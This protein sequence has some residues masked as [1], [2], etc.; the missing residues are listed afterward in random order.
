[1]EPG[2]LESQMSPGFATSMGP[3]G[4]KNYWRVVVGEC[5]QDLPA[6]RIRWKSSM[7]LFWNFFSPTLLGWNDRLHNNQRGSM[8][9]FR[10]LFSPTLERNVIITKGDGRAPCACF[11]T[12]L[13]GNVTWVARIP[14]VPR[15]CHFNGASGGEK[16]LT[17]S[18]SSVNASLLFSRQSTTTYR[19]SSLFAYSRSDTPDGF[20][21]TWVDSIQITLRLAIVKEKIERDHRD[22]ACSDR[23]SNGL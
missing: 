11:E 19:S 21:G 8:R 22:G 17:H 23:E 20:Y 9:L 10:K 14:D 2:S 4:G 12:R 5:K 6:R 16:R 3:L 13:L 18:P 1:M 15:V 7:R